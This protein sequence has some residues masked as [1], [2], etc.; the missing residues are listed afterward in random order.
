MLSELLGGS[1]VGEVM[2][3]VEQEIE[4]PSI[5]PLSNDAS[6]ANEPLPRSN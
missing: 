2:T 3:G 5:G 6:Q 1:Q 4:G